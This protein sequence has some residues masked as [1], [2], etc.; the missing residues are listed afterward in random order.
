MERGLIA[1]S[2]TVVSFVA[3]GVRADPHPLETS[4]DFHPWVGFFAKKVMQEA[5]DG[6]GVR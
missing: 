5:L 1:V 2:L 6:A 3:A 4:V